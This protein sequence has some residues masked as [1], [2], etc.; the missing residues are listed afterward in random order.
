MTLLIFTKTTGYRHDSIPAGVEALREL[1]RE[2]GI[3]TEASADAACFEPHRL[4]SFRAVA[5]MSTSGN[6]LDDEQRRAFAEFVQSGGGYLGVHAASA[7]ENDWPWYAE[8]VGARFTRHPELQPARL[9]VED[10]EHPA[11]AHLGREW[12]RS[13]EWYEFD[14]NPRPRVRVLVSVDETSYHGG[15]MGDHPLVWCR[16]LGA[17]RSLYTALGHAAAHYEE[18]ALRRHLAGALR[19]VLE[20][21]A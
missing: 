20:R 12:F 13:D 11:T 4:A 7:S 3:A 21:S 19:W 17:G 2:L 6:V 10:R 14:E 1:S 5:W 16:E 18:P 15:T 8:L 9:I